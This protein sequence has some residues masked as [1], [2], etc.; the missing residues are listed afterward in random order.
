[1]IGAL[2]GSIVWIII[3]LLGFYASIGGVAISYA[4]FT[5]YTKLGG[6]SNRVSI[7]IIILS[8]LIAVVF[9]EL[10]GLGIEVA[11]YLKSEDIQ[12]GLVQIV[13][14]MIEIIKDGESIAEMI[15]NMLFGLLFAGLGSL[16]LIK[17][18]FQTAK[19]ADIKIE[20]I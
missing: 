13:Q 12:L 6:K 18:M 15:P 10:V 7:I 4:S 1:M 14:I 3:G 17:K 8:I 16:G 11:K 20:K 5:G 19:A 2:L 9:S